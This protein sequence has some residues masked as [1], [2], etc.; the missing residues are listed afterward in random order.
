MRRIAW[1]NK[2]VIKRRPRIRNRFTF[3]GVS[4][5]LSTLA[6]FLAPR[7]DRNVQCA[8]LSSPI[9]LSGKPRLVQTTAAGRALRERERVDAITSRYAYASNAF[10]LAYRA[11]LA[12]D[13]PPIG[14][15][16]T[17]PNAFPAFFT[18][19]AHFFNRVA[20]RASVDASSYGGCTLVLCCKRT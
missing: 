16:P 8:R 15:K 2:S 10:V 19:S 1:R 6:F 20:S 14:T 9:D 17:T 3:R 18:A 4:L 13:L 7:A 12:A 11:F 5:S